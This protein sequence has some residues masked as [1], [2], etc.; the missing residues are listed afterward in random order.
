[1]QDKRLAPRRLLS[2]DIT[3]F[4]TSAV[5]TRAYSPYSAARACTLFTIGSIWLS[6]SMLAQKGIFVVLFHLQLYYLD[7]SETERV[8]LCF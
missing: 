4:S 2:Q 5:H 8:P 7:F 3:K 1:M 6:G